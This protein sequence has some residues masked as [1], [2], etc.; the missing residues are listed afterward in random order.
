MNNIKR[1]DF[2]LI[3]TKMLEIND[4]FSE[5]FADVPENMYY[6]KA[7]GAAKVAGIAKGSG[8]NFMP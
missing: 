2:I 5:N 8:N 1:G 7:I 3:L 6:Y 4:E